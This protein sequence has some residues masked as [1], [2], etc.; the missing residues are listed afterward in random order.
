MEYVHTFKGEIQFY[1]LEMLMSLLSIVVK[2][3]FNTQIFDIVKVIIT[4]L[5]VN[6]I[7]F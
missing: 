3:I 5:R 4:Q 2:E 7:V 1:Y 6:I